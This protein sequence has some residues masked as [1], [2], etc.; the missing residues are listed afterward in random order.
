[1]S[2]DLL[3]KLL[4]RNAMMDL[5]GD[6]SFARGEDYQAG[7][8]VISVTEDMGVIVAKVAGTHDYRVKL[9]VK[10]NRLDYACTC[11]VGADGDF[12]K[13]CV[14][15]GLEWLERKEKAVILD[16]H[17]KPPAT[18]NDIRNFLAGQDKSV[19]IDIVMEQS[20]EDDQL[21]NRLLMKTAKRDRKKFDL[22]TFR[23]AITNATAPGGFVE[24]RMAYGFSQG[25]EAVID[26]IEALLK[27]GHTT[28]VIELA[29]FALAKVEVALGS[30]DDSD[31]YMSGIIERLQEMHLAACEKARPD[32]EALAKRLFK[33]ET[34]TGYDTFY[35]AAATYSK[36]LG[37]KG[38]AVYRKLAKTRWENV[39]ALQS[40]QREELGSG[41][42]RITHIMED[43]A[44]ASGDIEELV[45]IKSRNLSYA[46]SYLEIAD[47]YKAA[48]KPDV[49]LDWAERG[50]KAFP[51][52]TDSR[53]LDFLTDEY[54]RRKRHDEAMQLVW[55]QFAEA[56]HLSSYQ[57]LKAHA[58]KISQWQG[59]RQKALAALRESLAKSKKEAEETRWTWHRADSSP[60]VEIF[61]WEKDADAAWQEASEGG[62]TDS[63]WLELAAL[64]KKAYPEDALGVYKKQ[65]EP[66]ISQKNDTAYRQVVNILENIRDLMGRL[67]RRAEFTQYIDSV[68]KTHKPKRNFMKLLDRVE[69][70]Q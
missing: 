36:V 59:W 24:Y 31:G 44:R 12:C 30:M 6:R 63:L 65:I 32:P 38:L 57:K 3:K 27:E 9:A 61:L 53:L 23:E 1:M 64:R 70:G 7:G 19:L 55:R 22:T 25:I 8:Q 4:T 60:L 54:H 40:G 69:W 26:Q 68:R 10:G 46:F 58:D 39:P 11:P 33:W 18:M 67:G 15:A 34:S 47:V 42:F 45:S 13:H 56:P 20:L 5:A 41:R 66:V 51:E 50:L 28:E 43:L 62:C 2:T 35:G 37:E 52:R 49:A 21:R 48:G 16:K 14:A 29:E 17:A